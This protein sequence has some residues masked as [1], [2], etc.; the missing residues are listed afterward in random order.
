[1]IRSARRARFGSSR[2]SVSL[3]VRLI[4]VPR[5]WSEHTFWNSR[6]EPR[7]VPTIARPH[8]HLK[9][10]T[11][12]EREEKRR[13]RGEEERRQGRQTEI[14]ERKKRKIRNS[15]EKCLYSVPIVWR[16]RFCRCSRQKDEKK[17][18]ERRSSGLSSDW[19]FSSPRE[20]L[21]ARRAS[22]SPPKI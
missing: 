2:T 16:S 14:E 21:Q 7:H 11:S 3:F 10:K 12:I 18:G 6:E 1:M 15:L 22:Q 17:R 9:L 4:T 19:L 5:H 8:V 13:A 20:Y